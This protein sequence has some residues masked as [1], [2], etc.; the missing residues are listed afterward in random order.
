M[1]FPY[2]LHECYLNNNQSL[3]SSR[4]EHSVC[5]M[6]CP[7]LWKSTITSAVALWLGPTWSVKLIAG[8]HQYFFGKTFPT[9]D[10]QCLEGAFWN[11][12]SCTFPSTYIQH[13]GEI[14]ALTAWITSHSQKL[15]R[16]SPF[17]WHEIKYWCLTGIQKKLYH[18]RHVC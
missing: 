6:F 13:W 16:C 11:T 12:T 4:P 14:F 1:H 2:L 7:R 18:D 3:T 10:L 17:Q 15:F 8:I 5:W 9:C